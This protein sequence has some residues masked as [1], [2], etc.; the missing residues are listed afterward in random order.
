M[1]FNDVFRNKKVLITGHTGF[2]GSWLTLW[3]AKLG[4][5]IVGYSNGIPTKPS[6]FEAAGLAS[7]IDHRIGDVRD[8]PMLLRMI[9]ETRPDFIFH[10]AAQA[11]VSSSHTDPIGTLSSNIMGTTNVLEA[12]RLL[13]PTCTAIIVTSDKCYENVEWVWG[14]KETDAL[15]GRDIY[16]ASKGAAE[17]VFH[18][19]FHSFFK[20]PDCRVRLATGRAGNVIGGGDWAKDR[21]VVDC[22]RSWSEGRPVE[23]RSPSATRPWQHVLE[24]LSG[25]MT[26]AERLSKT[27][28]LNGESFNFGPRAEQ[29]HTVLQLMSD[30]SKHWDFASPEHAYRVTD[31]I[32]FDGAGLLK[33]NC[34]KALFH[35]HWQATLNYPEVVHLVGSWYFDLYRRHADMHAQTQEQIKKYETLAVERGATWTK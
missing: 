24:P 32:S 26:L 21:I 33:L 12:L 1:I 16:S 4:A 3:L 7:R 6:L 11:I 2:K 9:E 13:N 8:L 23:L 27:P 20:R 25:Y 18:A 30:L 22:M 5:K 34:D 31:N 10:L 17:V 35:L 14:Y 29:N 19:Y 15:G 28:S